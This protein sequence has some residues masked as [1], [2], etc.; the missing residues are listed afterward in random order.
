MSEL[1][2]RLREVRTTLERPAFIPAPWPREWLDARTFG[3]VLTFVDT[4]HS[5][6]QFGERIG[7]LVGAVRQ[8]D[9]TPMSL[10][11]VFTTMESGAPCGRFASR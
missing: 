9:V 7:S 6:E 8:I 1:S 2:G 11:S 5:Q 10:R 3:N 4:R